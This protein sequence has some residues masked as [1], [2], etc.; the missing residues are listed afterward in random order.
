MSIRRVY[1]VILMVMALAAAGAWFYLRQH[2]KATEKAVAECVTPAPPPK[3]T[4][5]PPKLPGFAVEASCG[6]GEAAKPASTKK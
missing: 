4:T 5:R 2:A 6:P 3:P 1:L